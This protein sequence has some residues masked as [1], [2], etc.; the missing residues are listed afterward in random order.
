MLPKGNFGDY[1]DNWDGWNL[2]NEGRLVDPA[3][4]RYSPRDIEAAFYGKQLYK[5]LAGTP[6]HIHSLKQVLEQKIKNAPATTVQISYVTQ[7][8]EEKNRNR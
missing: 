2:D 5:S 1:H 3:G 6:F 8:G 4:N 7:G